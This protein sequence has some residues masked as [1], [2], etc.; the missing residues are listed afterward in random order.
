MTGR[1]LS[2]VAV[3]LLMGLVACERPSPDGRPLP[4]GPQVVDVEMR[5]YGFAYDGQ[6][7]AGRVV[8]RVHNRGD[9][10]HNLSVVPLT[11]DIPPIDE[12]LRGTQRRAITPLARVKARP[13]GTAT[14]IAVDL[15]AGVR[16]AFICF[17]LDADGQS[18]SL[19][20]MSSEFRAGEARVPG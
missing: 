20:G 6:I 2:V 15:T 16:Y 5:D 7:T 14:T 11:E 12:Q 9:V 13:P 1:T 4:A 3:A 17:V 18:H 10:A 8:F 19:R